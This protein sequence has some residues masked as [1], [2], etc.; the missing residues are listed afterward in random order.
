MKRSKNVKMITKEQF[1]L[2]S[3]F[4]GS[5]APCHIKAGEVLFRKGE[6]L[7]PRKLDIIA[8]HGVAKCSFQNK[9]VKQKFAEIAEA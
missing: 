7:T 4:V 2:R 3:I 5:P 1:N 8:A 6:K 9:L